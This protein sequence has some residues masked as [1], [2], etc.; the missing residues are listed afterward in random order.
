MVIKYKKPKD[1]SKNMMTLNFQELESQYMIYFY[2]LS[3]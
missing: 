1:T 3:I 2:I